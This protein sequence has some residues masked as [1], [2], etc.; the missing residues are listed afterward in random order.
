MPA[1]NYLPDVLETTE[2]EHLATGFI[3]TEGPLWHRRAVA[4]SCRGPHA[5][6]GHSARAA[7]SA[8]TTFR[9][10]L[11]RLRE[12]G[13]PGQWSRVH[14]PLGIN[15][16]TPVSTAILNRI[17]VATPSRISCMASSGRVESSKTHP[18][19]PGRQMQIFRS[20]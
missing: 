9:G 12:A 3:F 4:A 20:G 1:N 5:N 7:S 15:P 13:G 2:A 17:L 16:G 14:R 11:R 18:R 8:F 10:A 19:I 6:Q